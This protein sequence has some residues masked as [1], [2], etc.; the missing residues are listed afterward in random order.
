MKKPTEEQI[1][2]SI[3]DD[4]RIMLEHVTLQITRA[5]HRVVDAAEATNFRGVTFDQAD[6]IVADIDETAKRIRERES[7]KDATK[8]SAI[9]DILYTDLYNFLGEVSAV[10]D[11]LIAAVQN[12]AYEIDD[13]S[14]V[15]LGQSLYDRANDFQK[16]ISEQ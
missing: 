13:Y 11:I 12:E 8:E 7:S 9:E 1:K 6:R 4:N 16:R 10:G 15:W 5:A 3:E 14:F 2:R